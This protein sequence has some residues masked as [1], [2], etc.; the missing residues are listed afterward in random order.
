MLGLLALA[1][2]MRRVW[3]GVRGG[4]RERK[5]EAATS[6]PLAPALFAL[7]CWLFSFHCSMIFEAASL[8][9]TL[10]DL[11]EAAAARSLPGKDF[12]GEIFSDLTCKSGTDT[13]RGT[14]FATGFFFCTKAVFIVSFNPF[15]DKTAVFT[16]CAF[17]L[18]WGGV[19]GVGSGSA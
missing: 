17:S 3:Y 15:L 11:T 14:F 8:L 5:C 4:S 1:R 12:F 2:A 18:A 10:P 9:M 16:L 13:L 7:T 6:S 19:D